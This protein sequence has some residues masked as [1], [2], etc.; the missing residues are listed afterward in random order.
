LARAL[1]SSLPGR[2]AALDLAGSL[3][4]SLPGHRRRSSGALRRLLYFS[5]A[6]AAP[7]VVGCARVAPE[8]RVDRRSRWSSRHVF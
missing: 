6:P 8:A 5:R 3:R 7:T 2:R 4:S 1:P